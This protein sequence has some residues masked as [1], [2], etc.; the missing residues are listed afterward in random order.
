M[1]KSIVRTL[2]A[3]LLLSAVNAGIAPLAHAEALKIGGTGAALGTMRL[4]AT[5]FTR[6]HPAAAIEVLPS[7]GSSGGIKALAAGSIDLAVSSR[8]LKEAERA[9]GLQAQA[10]GKTAL[11]FATPSDNSVDGVTSAE[12]VAMF[13]GTQGAWPN[14]TQARPILRPKVE[15]DTKLAEE[16]ITGLREAFESARNRPAVPLYYT[17]QEAADALERIPGSVGT[18]SLS[19][20]ISERRDLKALALDGRAATPQSIADGSYPIT[21]TFFFVL[22]AEPS[23]F[24]KDFVAFVFSPEGRAI[25]ENNGHQVLPAVSG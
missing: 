6:G 4:L 12:V 22:P 5:A 10:Y 3:L 2:L 7:L 25:L 8:D 16:H 18:M 1:R 13:G 9:Q 24:A 17:D 21:K 14:G 11:V 23:Q 20:L 19:L 15:T